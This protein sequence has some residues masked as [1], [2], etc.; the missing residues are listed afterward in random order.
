MI[1]IIGLARRARKI[2]SGTEITI[3]GVRSGKVKLVILAN[4]ASLNTKK[5]VNDKCK[6]YGVT[7][8]EEFSTIELSDAIGKEN[9]KVIGIVDDGFSKSIL[10][11]KRK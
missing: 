3:N 11:Q 7:V 6:T 9:I 10:N 8:V 5:L 1:K 2:T 4:D